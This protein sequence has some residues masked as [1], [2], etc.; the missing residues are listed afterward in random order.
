MR[1]SVPTRSPYRV[2]I[3]DFVKVTMDTPYS[4]EVLKE[5]GSTQDDAR[6]LFSG[7]PVLVV[8]SEQTRGRGRG[9]ATWKT[10]P[11]AVATSLA[12][13]PN[14]P[15]D[16]LSLISLIAG[17][18]AARAI[19]CELKW[20][21]DVTRGGLKLGGIL[22]EAS[23]GIVVA[24]LGLNLWWPNPPSGVGAV[25]ETDP[26]PSRRVRLARAWADQL[27]SLVEAGPDRWPRDEYRRHCGTLGQEITWE[28]DGYGTAVDI[29]SDGALVVETGSGRTRLP[30]GVVRHVR[31]PG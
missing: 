27:L 2:R 8:A 17:V 26:G 4:I 6:A 29:D 12:L 24:G 3:L 31:P 19:E 25:Y 23:D 1:A 22:V 5:T 18:A 7:Q 21:N 9:G 15:S 10:A 13:A 14:W 30:S 28:P 11:C 20:P 16:R